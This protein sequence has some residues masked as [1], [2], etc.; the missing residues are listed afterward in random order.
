MVDACDVIR[1]LCLDG[2]EESVGIAGE[3]ARARDQGKKIEYVE[4][5]KRLAF[6]GSRTCNDQQTVELIHQAI[7]M[8]QPEMIITHGEPEGACALAQK[9]ARELG[10]PLKL[11]FLQL[12]RAA[13]K[14]HHRTKAVFED[15]NYCVFIHD[16]ES[17]GCSNELAIAKKMN[18]PYEYHLHDGKQ[19]QKSDNILDVNFDELKI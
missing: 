6:C 17:T 3:L 7:E 16:G 5:Y 9:A 18:I 14:F 12:K 13:G 4:R 11:H 8:H 19:D 10:L 2:W 15:C 1:V